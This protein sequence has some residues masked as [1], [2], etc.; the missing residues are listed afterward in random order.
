MNL[1][2][3]ALNLITRF[4]N[5]ES[6]ADVSL[7]NERSY[8]DELQ[9]ILAS[10]NHANAAQSVSVGVIGGNAWL[11]LVGLFEVSVFLF[12]I[13]AMFFYRQQ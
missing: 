7:P 11:W 4:M 2:D 5:Y 12:F 6:F 3:I 1:P 8:L 9:P 10:I 13:L